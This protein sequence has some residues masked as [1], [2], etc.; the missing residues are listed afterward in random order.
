[1]KSS[2]IEVR[3]RKEGMACVKNGDVTRHR[4]QVTEHEGRMKDKVERMGRPQ[5]NGSFY[6][7][8]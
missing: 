1:M 5:Y 4:I 7:A 8:T 6:V 3:I 2:G